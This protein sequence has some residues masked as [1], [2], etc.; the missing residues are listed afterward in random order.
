MQVSNV[1]SG[2]ITDDIV[3]MISKIA[4]KALCGPDAEYDGVVVTHGTDTL[5]ETAFTLDATLTCD[6]T[7][8]VVGAMRPATAIS[9][10]GPVRPF[11]L[12]PRRRAQAHEP[13]P[14]RRATSS[15]PSRRLCRRLRT[16]AASSSSSTTASARCARAS[17]SPR[18]RSLSSCASSCSSF[19]LDILL[20]L[21][22]AGDVLRQD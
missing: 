16:G 18:G 10:D 20:T 17:L 12:A 3:L 7:V 2:S 22:N 4:N 13:G 1:G 15:R 5:E 19:F 11:L 9:A 21:S 8:V 14:V 6:K